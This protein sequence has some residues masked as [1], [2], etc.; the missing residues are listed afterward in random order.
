MLGTCHRIIWYEL[1][2]VTVVISVWGSI[3][4]KQRARGRDK[5]VHFLWY[6]VPCERRIMPF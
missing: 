4:G 6:L 2:T 1:V 3:L 5:K